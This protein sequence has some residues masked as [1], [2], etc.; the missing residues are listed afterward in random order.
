INDSS[1]TSVTRIIRTFYSRVSLYKKVTKYEDFRQ[2]GSQCR[3]IVTTTL[4]STR[5]NIINIQ[6]VIM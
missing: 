4:I 1:L 2:E 3:I 6:R 5:I